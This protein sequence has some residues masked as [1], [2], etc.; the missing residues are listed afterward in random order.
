MEFVFNNTVSQ[1]SLEMRPR[2]CLLLGAVGQGSIHE[3]LH[4]LARFVYTYYHSL[5]VPRCGKGWEALHNLSMWARANYVLL[6]VRVLFKLGRKQISKFESHSLA[7]VEMESKKTDEH[8]DNELPESGRQ[9]EFL[10]KREREKKLHSNTKKK[11]RN[12]I[13]NHSSELWMRKS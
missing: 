3:Q 1:S 10:G 13:S 5:C 4:L 9:R 2:Q 12:N 11:G 7:A 6:V 8:H